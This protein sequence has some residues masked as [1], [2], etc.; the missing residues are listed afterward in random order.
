[1][2]LKAAMTPLQAEHCVPLCHANVPVSGDV[3]LTGSLRDVPQVLHS[4]A[5]AVVERIEAMQDRIAL[6]GRVIFRVLY[7]QGDPAHTDAIEASADFT[8]TCDCPGSTPRSQLCAR[9]EAG[10]VDTAVAAGRM[11]LKTIVH[12][13]VSGSTAAPAD[14]VGE[15]GNTNVQQRTE[16]VQLMRTVARG[17]SETLLREE[18]ALP[19][20]LGVR[21]TLF[22]DA[23][24]L[25]RDVSG[26]QG[27]IGLAGEITLDAVH[28][29]DVPGKPIATTRHVIPVLQA[30]DVL[31]DA[32]D[33]LHGR[34]A[35]KDVAVASQADD[36]GTVLRA[37]VL[38]ALD[39]WAD[40]Q[41]EVRVL[42]DAY[43]TNGDALHLGRTP[44]T[45]RT[46]TADETAAES[47]KGTAMLPEGAK[48]IRTLLAAFASPSVSGFEQQGNRLLVQGNMEVTLVYL[49]DDGAAPASAH[50]TL[51]LR[52]SF[53]AHGQAGDDAALHAAE[54]EAVPVTSDR[55]EVRCIL[56][57]HLSGD[58]T[59]TVDLVTEALPVPAEAPCGDIILCF[60]QPGET[61][62]DVAKR[63]RITPERLSQLNPGLNGE[64]RAGDGLIVWRQ[65]EEE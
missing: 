53:A 28:L 4:G 18:F 24:A 3:T 23:N 52:V 10:C 26:G 62:W 64:I 54:V 22:A 7:A 44:L 43:T 51:P 13:A 25:L 40:A 41:E 20:E 19:Q 34:I 38:L 32:G 33:T 29:S 37:E 35:V 46:G 11:G 15:I 39:A 6:S 55:A 63:Y 61:L 47:F 42:T 2:E 36:N 5:L 30:V 12:I 59:R 57:L 21:D 56:Q 48:P 60:A 65:S 45:L 50:M 49:P 17:Q 8:H 1:M 27:K 58:R 16:T 9:A 14:A 31:G